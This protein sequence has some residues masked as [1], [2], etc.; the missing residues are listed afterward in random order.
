MVVE[1]PSYFC[2][3]RDWFLEAK[4][5]VRLEVCGIKLGCG[6]DKI[7]PMFSRRPR[8]FSEIVVGLQCVDGGGA[9][10]TSP[11]TCKQGSLAKLSA[12]KTLMDW[13][14]EADMLKAGVSLMGQGYVQRMSLA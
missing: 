10:R 11:S 5:S 13:E 9:G 4:G 7:E 1:I 6:D 12:L 3:G 2:L 8:G 14:G